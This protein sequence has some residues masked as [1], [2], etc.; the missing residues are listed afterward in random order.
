M[1][2]VMTTTMPS[3]TPRAVRPR[4]LRLVV[5]ATRPAMPAPVAGARRASHAAYVRRRVAAAVL[6]LVLVVVAGRAAGAALGGGPLVASE[7][8]PSVTTYVVQ[9][10]DSLWS[11]AEELEAGRDPRP[12]VDALAEARGGAPLV[13]GETI[14]WL[15]G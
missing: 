9:P 13:P 11:I 12:V 2:A 4:P 6:G 10:G 3:P 1:A 5:P 15:Q 8:R 7:R 14:T